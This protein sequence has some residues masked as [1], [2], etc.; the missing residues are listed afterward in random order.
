MSIIG[1]VVLIILLLFK[2]KPSPPELLTGVSKNP[3]SID[4]QWNINIYIQPFP[5]GLIGRVSWLIEEFK[6]HSW[7]S[8]EVKIPSLTAEFKWT[9][10][11]LPYAHCLYDIR[12]ALRSPEATDDA[13]WSE[14]KS[15]TVRTLSKPP[16]VPPKTTLGMFQLADGTGT[17]RIY[18]QNILANQENG[19]NFSYFVE[20]DGYPNIKPSKIQ[21]NYAEFQK[22]EDGNYTIRIWSINE[23]GKSN[24]SSAVFFPSQKSCEYLNIQIEVIF[25]LNISI[26][27][28]LYFLALPE[29]DQLIKVDN[30]G[31]S[32]DIQWKGTNDHRAVS[33]TLF[34]CSATKERPHPC[35][36]SLF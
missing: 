1:F 23:E 29:V 10:R 27:T 15:V 6:N 8:H 7:T 13:L 12:V 21:N 26:I 18:W 31:G 35:D 32:F 16:D 34:W 11:D 3:H 33:Y 17:K 19:E 20:V 5:I 24:T 14:Y 28:F 30:G 9:L 25:V 4:L 36:V 22:L 2:V